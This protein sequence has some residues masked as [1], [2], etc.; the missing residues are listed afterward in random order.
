MNKKNKK[1]WYICPNEKEFCGV[2]DYVK[3]LASELTK[4]GHS[5]KIVSNLKRDYKESNPLIDRVLDNW[6]LASYQRLL[7][8]IKQENP[9]HI[10]IHFVSWLYQKYGW[11]FSLAIFLT[12][13]R[14][15]EIPFSLHIHETYLKPNSLK[16]FIIG[17]I[18]AICFS[19]IVMICPLNFISIKPWVENLKKRYFFKKNCFFWLPLSANL[20]VNYIGRA[21]T[22]ISS[23]FSKHFKVTSFAINK[24]KS[25]EK[26]YEYFSDLPQKKKILIVLGQLKGAEKDFFQSKTDVY[27]DKNYQGKKIV[28]NLRYSDLF[29]IFFD[30]GMSSRR[31]SVMPA[32]ALGK[33]VLTNFGSETD[34]IF[35]KSPL[36]WSNIKLKPE[37]L[38]K[39]VL[40]LR[41]NKTRDFYN[42]Y[43]MP[44]VIVKKFLKD[45]S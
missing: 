40:K 4:S 10:N 1:I 29:L 2:F 21:S 24:N 8:L 23:K 14:L 28:S 6:S 26:I 18:Q 39:K 44:S 27:I 20:P 30:N 33:P 7:K 15:N 43:F 3:V 11:S 38:T 25:Y 45:I 42:R 13:L 34:D 35:E 5:V 17:S 22:I 19:Y 16:S 41:G 9:D 37:S 31:T 12:Q 32:L 36:I